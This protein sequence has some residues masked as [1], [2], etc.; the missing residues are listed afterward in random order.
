MIRNKQHLS[1][2]AVF[3]EHHMFLTVQWLIIA[4]CIR[5]NMAVDQFGHPDL[6]RVL[7]HPQ[8]TGCP[9]LQDPVTHSGPTEHLRAA[10]TT[11][12]HGN[13]QK[14][15]H[16][17]WIFVS[18]FPNYRNCVTVCLSLKCFYVTSLW[19]HCVSLQLAVSIGNT[20]FNDIMEACLPNDSVKPLPQS[21]M[22]VPDFF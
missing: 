3:S 1:I 5:S 19:L 13:T 16:S 9:L 10:G 7:W 18:G 8:R 20:R 14:Q 22:W 12:T 6:Y 4:L 2:Q 21:D 17:L 11:C 15:T